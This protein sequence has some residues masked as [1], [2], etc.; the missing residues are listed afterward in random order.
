[1]IEES[2]KK[3]I[4]LS[5][6]E[7][8]LK[9]PTMYVGSTDPSEEKVPVIKEGKICQEIRIVSVGFYKMFNEILDNSFDEA[10]RMNGEMKY[11]KIAIDSK[12]NKI[13]IEDS[14]GGFYKGI[15]TNAKTGINN[16]DTAMTKLRAGSNFYNDE[17]DEALIGTNGVGAALVNMLSESFVIETRTTKYRYKRTWKKFKPGTISHQVADQ[18]KTGTKISFIPREDIF[19]GCSWN[20][21]VIECLMVLKNYQIKLDPLLKKLKLEVKF[22]GN[23]LNLK[24]NILPEEHY[25]GDTSI[26]HLAIWESFEGSASFSFIN[27]AMCIGVHQKMFNDYI[28]E[29]LGDSLAHHF[30]ETFIILNLP[31]KLVRFGDQNK[32]RFVSTR[33]E[34]EEIIKQE[35]D[36]KLKAFYRSNLFQEI[37]KKVDDRKR[38]GEISS[39]KAL[40]RKQRV[41]YSHK[42]HSASGNKENLFIVE[43]LSAG[44]S[45]LQKRDTKHE[46]VY[47]LKGKIKNARSIT[48]LINNKEIMELMKILDLDIEKKAPCTYD[49]IVIS[50]DADPDGYHICSLL[51]NLFYRWFPYI[52]R[53]GRL[54][55]MATPLISVGDGKNREYYYSN[56][57]FHQ[58]YKN[59]TPNGIRYLKG[60]GSL[61][62]EDWERV[63]EHKMFYQIKDDKRAKEHIEIA[64]G[65]SS[66]LRKQWL[67]IT[68]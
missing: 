5:D 59:K 32:T 31:P 49:R 26:G 36:K 2:N 43:G 22:D 12:N 11:I 46:G 51:I 30:Y 45:L 16:I 10:K 39:L 14:G 50:T 17:I 61:S 44:G 60:L 58:R 65:H 29:K 57:E 21:E 34:I 8:V 23:K 24:Q 19:P 6:F 48:D 54:Y 9:R 35:F 63:M 62:I 40:K 13:T 66:Q 41:Q 3:I 42:Y 28:N 20:Q 4:A 52:V 1:M 67:K 55:I 47:S 7:H 18:S 27:S 56:E 64:F 15:E 33:V 38:K 25:K 37:K 53:E 68:E